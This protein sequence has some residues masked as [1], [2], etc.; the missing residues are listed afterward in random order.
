MLRRLALEP[1]AVLGVRA[2]GAFEF[3][4]HEVGHR[5]LVRVPPVE[6]RRQVTESLRSVACLTGAD[7]RDVAFAHPCC[8]GA[9]R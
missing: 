2:S 9:A 4:A 8:F 5:N 3:G 1:E 7:A 6:G